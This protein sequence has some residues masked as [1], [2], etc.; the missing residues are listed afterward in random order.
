MQELQD[1]NSFTFTCYI[2]IF[3]GVKAKQIMLDRYLFNCTANLFRR[4][5]FD[6][7]KAHRVMVSQY[8]MFCT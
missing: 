8:Q 6:Y 7:D 2:S 3:Y 4:V 5:L 1:V